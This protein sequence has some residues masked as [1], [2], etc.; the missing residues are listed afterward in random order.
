MHASDRLIET[1]RRQ[2]VFGRA[3]VESERI[4]MTVNMTGADEERIEL[5]F[6]LDEIAQLRR[7]SRH[8]R[9]GQDCVQNKTRADKS[10]R[11]NRCVK[12]IVTAMRILP[13]VA[14]GLRDAR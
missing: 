3:R 11:A 7:H 8:F 2:S 14:A 4:D 9:R 1:A 5:I 10:Q 13:S 6:V 12:K